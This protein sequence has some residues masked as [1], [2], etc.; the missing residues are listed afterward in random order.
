[1]TL[2][3]QKVLHSVLQMLLKIPSKSLSINKKQKQANSLQ[4]DHKPDKAQLETTKLCWKRW[5]VSV[6]KIL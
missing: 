4:Y 5:V 6:S 3:F 1:M 2:T